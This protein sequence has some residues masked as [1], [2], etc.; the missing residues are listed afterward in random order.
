MHSFAMQ[1]TAIGAVAKS[2][3]KSEVNPLTLLNSKRYISYT[4]FS[5]IY[6]QQYIFKM[7]GIPTPENPVGLSHPGSARTWHHHGRM[8][9]KAGIRAGG[10]RGMQPAHAA[11]CRQRS[12]PGTDHTVS[13]Q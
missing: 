1:N 5:K 12:I 11:C 8:V 4:D 7:E 13:G 2:L 6:E 10:G 3:A 9:R